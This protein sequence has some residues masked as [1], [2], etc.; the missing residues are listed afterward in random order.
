VSTRKKPPKNPFLA[1]D[2]SDGWEVDRV[3][4]AQEAPDAGAAAIA[5]YV[6][7]R[8][9]GQVVS[10]FD[11]GPTSVRVERVEEPDAGDCGAVDRLEH[12]LRAVC[13]YVNTGGDLELANEAI[14]LLARSGVGAVQFPPYELVES[15]E[16]SAHT[17]EHLFLSHADAAEAVL[18]A[19]GE[20]IVSA[21]LDQIRQMQADSQD[22][23]AEGAELADDDEREDDDEDAG[24]DTADA[25]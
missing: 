11:S 14:A 19:E 12:L 9:G 16:T 8:A 3:V 15:V 17:F 10:D 7:L 6:R 25:D 18:W 21:P 2:P 4:T 24:P 22:D 5:L 1:M 20:F 23:G 13:R